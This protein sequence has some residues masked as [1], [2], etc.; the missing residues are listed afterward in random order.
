[1]ATPKQLKGSFRGV[2]FATTSA[3]M[4]SGRRTVTHEFPGKDAPYTEDLGRK[5]RTFQLE[6]FVVGDDVSQ[7]RDNLIKALETKGPGTLIHPYLGFLTVQ[8]SS[9]SQSEASESLRLA[10]FAVTFIQPGAL[11]F[12]AASTN[13][14]G[15]VSSGSTAA[16]LQAGSNA[17]AIDT[18]T[19]DAETA[20]SSLAQSTVQ[21]VQTSA[22]R[23]A[24]P[25]SLSSASAT[26]TAL[27]A[28]SQFQSDASQVAG[29]IATPDLMAYAM[30]DIVFRVSS[31]GMT[32]L[33]AFGVYQRMLGDISGIF[34][35]LTFPSTAVGITMAANTSLWQDVVY[36]AIVGSAASCAVDADFLTYDQAIATRDALAS[37]FDQVMYIV[38]DDT[39]F[40]NLQD[41]RASSLNAI[42]SPDQSL[43]NVVSVQ[44]AAPLPSLCLSHDLMSG[45]ADEQTIINLNAVGNPWFVPNVSG[46]QVLILQ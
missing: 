2:P 18:S 26:S 6:I 29:M 13:A 43:P 37:M 38:T 11:E 8:V 5:A 16:S 4:E 39:L 31:L 27:A 28:M 1:M 34:S 9:F 15:T 32:S 33:Q 10:N 19:P 23:S 40:G 22:L 41:L 17:A 7:Q 46:N 36:V 25:N 12:P 3:T 45:S 24:Q 21:T 20:A 42:P 30:A 14:S 35:G 44:V